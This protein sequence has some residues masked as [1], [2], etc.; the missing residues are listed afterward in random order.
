MAVKFIIH[1][2]ATIKNVPPNIFTQ[3]KKDLTI[4]NP[5]YTNQKRM[6]KKGV[7]TRC[8]VEQF[9]KLYFE[10]GSSSIVVPRG[11]MNRAIYLLGSNEY[12]IIDHSVCPPLEKEL[13]FSATLRD[14]QER[15][16]LDTIKRRYGILEA[17]TGAGKTIMAIATIPKRNTRTLIIVHNVELMN[18]WEKQ[19]QSF[20]GVQCGLIGNGKFILK[21]ITVGIINSVHKKVHQFPNEFGYVIYDEVHRAM[22]NTWLDVINSMIPRYHLG[23]TA[24]PFRNDETTKGLFSVVGPKL[25]VVDRNELEETG[26]ILVPTIIRVSTNL[27]VPNEEQKEYQEIVSLLT[28]DAQ[29]N[30][31]IAEKCNTDWNKYKEPLLVVSDRVSHCKVL[32]ELIDS[33][34]NLNPI[35]IHGGTKKTDRKKLIEDFK[36]GIYNILVATI[37]LIGEGFDSPG[38]NY[39]FLTTPVKYSGRLLQSIG[40]CI[41]PSGTE[42]P[43]VYD[44]RDGL[45]SM[46]RYSGFARDRLYKK[47]WGL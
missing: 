15:A 9:L 21:D 35:L 38:I 2:M 22:G 19:I 30:I 28:Q 10:R 6:L 26:A 20:L 16:V 17:A 25:H 4:E 39:I 8:V 46:L 34:P 32:Y 36:K 41:R 43:R 23:V 40:R 14:Y 5:A 44:F 7:L 13:T 12:E 1:T 18:Q 47:H 3:I 42:K 31:L 37:S 11:Y 27:W 29:R 24:T 45:V 33:Y